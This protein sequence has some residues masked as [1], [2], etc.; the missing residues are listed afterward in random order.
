MSMVVWT[1]QVVTGLALGAGQFT[2]TAGEFRVDIPCV[3]DAMGHAPDQTRSFPS[4]QR[5]LVPTV[6]SYS[7]GG[8][9][10]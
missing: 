10:R 9:R 6:V 3:A 8:G 5:T 7:A 1:S 4:V 2:L